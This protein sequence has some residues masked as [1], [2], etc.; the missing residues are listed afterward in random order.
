[1]KDTEKF[2]RWAAAFK[3]KHGTAPAETLSY[4]LANSS[5]ISLN[6]MA[7]LAGLELYIHR[8]WIT[9]YPIGT[10]VVVERYIERKTMTKMILSTGETIRYF[11]DE[12]KFLD[13]C[14]HEVADPRPIWET[15]SETQAFML[16]FQRAFKQE[17]ML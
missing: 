14:N 15:K 11:F 17:I 8:K 9:A 13:E 5:G 7:N 10:S 16:C 3:R 4:M 1:M 6:E 2:K 12:D